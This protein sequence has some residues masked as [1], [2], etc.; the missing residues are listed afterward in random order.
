ME[1]ATTLKLVRKQ[2][3]TS[4]RKLPELQIK[5]SL[6][7]CHSISDINRLL[8]YCSYVQSEQGEWQ[9]TLT[10]ASVLLQRLVIIIIKMTGKTK[11]DWLQIKSNF[12]YIKNTL[13]KNLSLLPLV[14]KWHFLMVQTIVGNRMLHMQSESKNECA[15][16]QE[17]VYEE[18]TDVKYNE[19][20]GRH[21][22]ANRDI[23]VGETLLID[24]NPLLRIIF[25][26]QEGQ[27]YDTLCINC[28]RLTICSLPCPNCPDVLFCSF[29]CLDNAIQTFHFYECKMRLYGFL[30]SISK[31]TEEGMSVGRML[32]LRVSRTVPDNAWSTKSFNF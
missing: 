10:L 17:R 20:R 14:N 5:K 29:A 30:R 25:D 8:R 2:L 16:L 22:V 32:P 9:P 28:G 6:K 24:S 26:P 21:Y 19:D 7:Q 18:S 13:S 4:P 27:N 31:P 11:K 23:S 12:Y 15:I 1:F 3:S